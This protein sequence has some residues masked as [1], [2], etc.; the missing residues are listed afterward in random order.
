MYV[1]AYE[2]LKQDVGAFNEEFLDNVELPEIPVNITEKSLE[3]LRERAKKF[4]MTAKRIEKRVS[5]EDTLIV[6]NL[7]DL[8]RAAFDYAQPSHR[9]AAGEVSPHQYH[10]ARQA[11]KLKEFLKESIPEDEPARRIKLR[12]IKQDWELIR[13]ACEVFLY[14]SDQSRVAEAW[15]EIRYLITGN[16]AGSEDIYDLWEG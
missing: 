8:I 3:A 16:G 12:K 15:A 6:K 2:K 14:D 7:E 10:V 4:R 9:T 13:S 5:S 11:N 1:K